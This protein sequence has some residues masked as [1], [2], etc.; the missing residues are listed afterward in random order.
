MYTIYKI[1]SP[2]GKFYVGMTSQTPRARW[3]EH[4]SLAR[5]GTTWNPFHCAIRKY[6]KE[7]FVHEVLELVDTLEQ[8]NEAEI[9]W[10]AEL[11]STDRTIGYNTSPGGGYDSVAGVE[12]MRVKLA[13]PEWA[14]GYR[15]RL[16]RGIR[17]R[18][19]ESWDTWIAAGQRWREEN[20]RQSYKNGHRAVRLATK[21]QNRPWTGGPGDGKRMRG[22][23]GRLWIPSEKVRWARH[24]YFTKRH[25]KDN[26]ASLDEEA[27]EVRGKQISEGQK[28]A[29]QRDPERK[30]KNFEQMKQARANV[31]R[32][33]QAA[34]ASAG[35]KNWWA[36]LRKDPERY[37]EYINRRRES[38][39]ANLRHR[40]RGPEEPLHD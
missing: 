22:T 28:A 32:K 35:Q 8:A 15:A 5:R 26:W 39:L 24:A 36:E 20:P 30:A 33:K 7:G 23:W 10:I 21:A 1:I 17:N 34:A 18:P 31:D 37:A 16:S 19:R 29:Y 3:D 40:K 6:G 38:L 2:S 12:G 25:V 27:K 13:D 4:C 9:K 14:A 11:R